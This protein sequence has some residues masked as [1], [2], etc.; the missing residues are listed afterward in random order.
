MKVTNKEAV[1][2]KLS[3]DKE[4]Y[5][6]YG[7]Q[8]LSYSNIDSLIND[9]ASYGTPLEGFNLTFGKAFHELVMFGQTEL[10][11]CVVDASRRDT[12]IYKEKA[13]EYGRDLFLVK[14]YDKLMF[15][16]QKAQDNKE[17]SELILGK[18]AKYEVPGVG[19]LFDEEGEEV[20]T[21]K[22]KADIIQPDF[23]VDLKTTSSL[24]G[25]AR[26]VRSYDYDSQAYIYQKL[27]GKPMKFIAFDKNTG[28][29]G[30]FDVGEFT[31]LDGLNKAKLA[32]E[33]YIKYVLKKEDSISNHTIYG[34]V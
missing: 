18:D 4:Y 33:N 24:K 30:I 8:F 9:P 16:V 22:G 15:M 3:D 29:A 6:D 27:F 1:L 5:G 28:V 2:S 11:D 12:N 21:W 31:L 23:I 26:S 34:T 20:I 14:E 17:V 13:A 32:Q 19:V 25:F 10:I 7:K